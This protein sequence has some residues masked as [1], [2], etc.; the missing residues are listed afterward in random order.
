MTGDFEDWAKENNYNLE[1][2]QYKPDEFTDT[3]IY[4]STHTQSAWE[5]WDAACILYTGMG[6]DDFKF[7]GED[8]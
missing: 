3:W 5:A 2:E 8:E 7:E 4:K 1:M 6:A